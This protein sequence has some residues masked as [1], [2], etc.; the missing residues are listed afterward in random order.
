MLAFFR[1]YLSSWPALILLALILVAFAVTGVGND[2]FGTKGA[3]QGSIAKA[4]DMVI[5]E[6]QLTEQFGRT[7]TR[8]RQSDPSQTQTALARQGGVAAVAE[9]M[10]G[11]ASIEAFARKIGV[12]ASD[13]AVG[14]EIAAIP[15]FQSGGKFDE[16]AYRRVIEEQRLSDKEI[17]AGIAGDII[18]KQLLTPL[19]QSL[20][21]PQGMAA[22]YARMLVDVHKGEIASVPLAAAPAATDA[23]LASWYAAHK[24]QFTLPERR[25]FRYAMI[26]RAVIAAGIKVSETDIAAAFAANR[27]KYGGDATRTLSQ[28]VVPDEAKAR[29]I[30][31]AAKVEGF[32]KAATRLGGVTVADLSLG[33]QTQPKFAGATSA[34]VAAAAFAAPVGSV[35]EPIKTDFGWHV[36][37]I[38]AVGAGGKSLA[39]VRPAVL[40]DLSKV[41]IDKAVAA[42]VAKIDDGAEA[43]KSFPDIAKTNGLTLQTSPALTKDGRAGVG[44]D[45]A[46]AAPIPALAA[47]AFGH[48]PSDG[49]GVEDMGGGNFA[50]IETTQVVPP[51]PLP[52]AAVR[53]RVV[54]AVAQDK[55]L[56]LAK[57][58]ADAVV[59][60]VAKGASFA[61]ALQAQGL[62]APQPV[63]TRRIDAD[64]QKGVPPVVTA[65]LQTPPGKVRT[66][67]GSQ[68]WVLI[69]VES[70]TPG[71]LSATP[72]LIESAR[73]AF[74][75][76]APDE[77]SAALAAAAGKAVKVRRNPAQI[78]AVQN[79]LAGQGDAGAR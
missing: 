14:A 62:A 42:L 3:P 27:D 58:K 72:Q 31:A 66:I 43:G 7:V 26:D 4:G 75:S 24:A 11:G 70:V 28:I 74:A 35:T 10:I 41:A 5:T 46:A 30:A 63:S 55:A 1:K 57:T 49:V 13:R 45:T 37:H 15:A 16:N 52:L 40:A 51:S 67:A 50:A 38:D 25:A 69:H 12:A 44:T 19:T 60:A 71:D 36:V 6:R 77:F 22:P 29:A 39:D 32:V 47:K 9:Q 33:S 78:A 65:F 48:E 54:A 59:A 53:D 68:G 8:V 73:Q 56:A 21:V 79:R 17:R 18:R 61:A 64:Q 20:S 34:A 76:Q 23:E 2:P